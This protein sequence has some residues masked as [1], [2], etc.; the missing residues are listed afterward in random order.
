MGLIY[1]GVH[2]PI[3]HQIKILFNVD[4][5]VETGTYN[6]DTAV[7]ASKYFKNV[8]TI[9]R[10]RPIWQKTHEKYKHLKNINFLFGDSAEIINKISPLLDKPTIFWLDAHYSEGI[11]YGKNDECALLRELD[12]ILTIKGNYFILIDDARLFLS[13]PPHPHIAIQWPDFSQIL[14]KFEK[15]SAHYA[16]VIDDVIIICPNSAKPVLMDFFQDYSTQQ[17]ENRQIKQIKKTKN[18]KNSNLFNRLITRIRIPNK[19]H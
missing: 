11:T 3:V 2:K 15:K 8:F 14:S 17:W 10:S 4:V 1:P 18:N 19:K 6:G 12:A 5:F 7:W 9:E 16:V 13:P